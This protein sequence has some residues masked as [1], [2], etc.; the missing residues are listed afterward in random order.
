ML[1]TSFFVSSSLTSAIVDTNVLAK[2]I[3]TVYLLY[4]VDLNL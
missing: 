4:N 2:I 3:C 1:L